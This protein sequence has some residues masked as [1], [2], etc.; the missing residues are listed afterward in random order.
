MNRTAFL[1]NVTDRTPF[2]NEEE[3]GRLGDIEADIREMAT[4]IRPVSTKEISAAMPLPAYVAHQD[5][6]SEVGK[7][8]S[9]ALVQEY[10]QAAKALE[11]TAGR[12]KESVELNEKQVL[13]GVRALEDLRTKA[14]SAVS[15]LESTAAKY[16]DEAKRI[17]EQVQGSS[18]VA[19]EVRRVCD[20]LSAKIG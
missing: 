12:L 14:D 11:E 10:E 13:E 4:R 5:K 9:A 8:T 15:A 19:D 20:E 16:R 18:Q 1:R 3:S 6:T 7:I 2:P 17:F